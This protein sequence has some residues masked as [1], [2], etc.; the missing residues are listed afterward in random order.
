MMKGL[1]VSIFETKGKGND[2]SKGDSTLT[3]GL[4]DSIAISLLGLFSFKTSTPTFGIQF[5]NSGYFDYCMYL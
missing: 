4:R 2:A 3:D 5:A 1:K